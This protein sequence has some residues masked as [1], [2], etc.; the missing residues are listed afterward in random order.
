MFFFIFVVILFLDVGCDVML[1][2]VML[3]IFRFVLVVRDYLLVGLWYV[4]FSVGVGVG[5]FYGWYDGE[6]GV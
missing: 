4:K 1:C 3:C 6:R 2:F 5:V